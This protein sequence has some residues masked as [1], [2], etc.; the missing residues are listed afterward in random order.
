MGN[1][2]PACTA[3]HASMEGQAVLLAASLFLGCTIVEAQVHG[4]TVAPL[5]TVQACHRADWSEPF[6]PLALHE[7]PFL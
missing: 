5:A 1:L 6:P 4:P 7:L 3:R 2:I